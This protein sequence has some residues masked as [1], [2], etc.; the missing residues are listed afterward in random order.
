MNTLTIDL[1]DLIIALAT[2][3]ELDDPSHYLDLDTG[4]VIY[5]GEGLE[6]LPPDLATHPRYRWIESVQAEPALHVIEAF[7]AQLTDPQARATLSAAFHSDEPFEAFKDAMQT[8]P[9]LRDEWFAHHHQAY[10]AMAQEWCRQQ[11]IEAQW[12]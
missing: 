4:E 2:R 6:A 1:D 12:Q 3:Y 10:S 5:A 11:G 9:A 8:L 7:I